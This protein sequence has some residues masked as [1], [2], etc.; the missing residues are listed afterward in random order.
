MGTH[1]ADVVYDLA[2]TEVVKLWVRVRADAWLRSP[3]FAKSSTP[4]LGVAVALR[5]AAGC[6]QRAALL[7]RAK[8]DG[9]QRTLGYLNQY[10]ATTG[11]GWRHRNDCFACMHGDSRLSDAIAAIKQRTSP[12]P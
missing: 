9:D 1:G 3:D 8:A 10:R 2:A 4:A 5:F 11:C 6:P 12:A 7:T